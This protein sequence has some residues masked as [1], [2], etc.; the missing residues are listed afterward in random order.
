MIDIDNPFTLIKYTK[1][2][3]ACVLENVDGSNS[4]LCQIRPMTTVKENIRITCP[5][6]LY[7]LC[8]PRL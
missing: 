8:I 1:Y 6:D 2:S 5:C 3:V 4:G 7:P